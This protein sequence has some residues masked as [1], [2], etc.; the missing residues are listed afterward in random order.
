MAVTYR[1]DDN[2]I[3]EINWLKDHL[4]ISTTT[5]LI[6]YLVDQYRADQAKMSALQR[7]LYEARSKS[8]S[9]E[10]AVSNFKEAFE[11]LMEI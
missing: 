1:P 9:M 10:Y 5:K 3:K 6:D 4:G 7:D 8:E 2:R 11:E